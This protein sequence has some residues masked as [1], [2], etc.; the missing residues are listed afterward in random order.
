MGLHINTWAFFLY[1]YMGLYINLGPPNLWGPVRDAHSAH[2]AARACL[3]ALSCW[4]WV[5]DA[6]EE[7]L[8]AMLGRSAWG[9]GPV[10]V[11]R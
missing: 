9:R 11:V 2:V 10:V 7:R 6:I 5:R 8:R 1:K 3:R 4:R